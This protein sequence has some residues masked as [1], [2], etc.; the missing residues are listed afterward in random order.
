EVESFRI[1]GNTIPQNEFA[2]DGLRIAPSQPFSQK[3]VDDDRNKIM[4]WYLD[5][6]YLSATLRETAEPI[7]NNPHRF[8]VV[9]SIHEGPQVH[10][11][12]LVTIGRNH[13][14]QKVID[15]E[16]TAVRP[17]TPL[18]ERN[19]LSSESRLYSP[20]IFDWA[21]VETRRPVTDQAAE[22]V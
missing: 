18:A 4:A 9:Y 22:N 21:E 12:E 2:P 16:I 3:N 5:H 13:T 19:L 1:E 14:N 20:G 15:R 17:G 6:G 8:N 10:T 7:T 11:D